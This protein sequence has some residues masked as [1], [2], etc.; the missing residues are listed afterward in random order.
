MKF[1]L[2]VVDAGVDEETGQYNSLIEYS[3][4]DAGV[5]T[6]HEIR[7]AT[8]DREVDMVEIDRMEKVLRDAGVEFDKLKMVEHGDHCKYK[9]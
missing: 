8:R 1:P 2:V 6:V 3:C 4:L 5:T 9:C 7:I